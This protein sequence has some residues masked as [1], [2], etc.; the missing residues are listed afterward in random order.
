[1]TGTELIT[2]NNDYGLFLEWGA[3]I[4][5]GVITAGAASWITLHFALKR[6]VSEK[7]WEKR[8]EAYGAILEALH[9]MK[10]YPDKLLDTYG[11]ISPEIS[12]DQREKLLM[13]YE[14]GKHELN[15][16]VEIEQFFLSDDLLTEMDTLNKKLAEAKAADDGYSIVEDS[17]DAIN[18]AQR[19]VREVAK[20]HLAVR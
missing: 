7:L 18:I 1:M 9:D 12:K 13:K 6:F 19:N 15:R 3:R 5:V 11:T 4:I 2:M 17:W 20:A 16:R 8:A 14:E 10:R